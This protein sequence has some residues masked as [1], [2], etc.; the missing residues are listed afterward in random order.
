MNWLGKSSQKGDVWNPRSNADARVYAESRQTFTNL[1][2]M[3]VG[4]QTEI[5][6]PKQAKRVCSEFGFSRSRGQNGSIPEFGSAFMFLIV[7]VLLPLLNLSF[8]PLRYMLCEGVISNLT[9]RLAHCEKYSDAEKMLTNET[10]HRNFLNT[11]GVNVRNE[12]IRLVASS[13]A[14]GGNRVKQGDLPDEYLPGGSFS[15][16]IYSLEVQA[17]CTIS[18]LYQGPFKPATIKLT[19]HSQWENL[20]KNPKTAQY[21]IN[22]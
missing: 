21:F 15:P 4:S 17:D 9:R 14:G 3:R 10:W 7:F 13:N 11:C 18:A 22:E 16:C 1:R 20:S 6:K 8:V 2:R 5:A 12:R 19:T